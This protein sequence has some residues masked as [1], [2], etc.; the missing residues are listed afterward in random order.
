MNYEPTNRESNH[1]E[2]QCK[3]VIIIIIIISFKIQI[4]YSLILIIR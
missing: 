2:V 1:P 3:N 4:N